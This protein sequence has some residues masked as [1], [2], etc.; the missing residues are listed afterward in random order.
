MLDLI[1]HASGDLHSR[2]H[3][4]CV[5]VDE[6]M[7]CYITSGDWIRA[8]MDDNNKLEQVLK[9]VGI[10]ALVAVPIFFLVKKLREN[11]TPRSRA[12][13]SNIFTEE[14]AD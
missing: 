2:D 6:A 14:L 3:V 9:I 8:D 13:D 10:A 4:T 11:D 5:K 1:G 12:E 7:I